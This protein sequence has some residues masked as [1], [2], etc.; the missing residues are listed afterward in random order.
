[1]SCLC[2]H[3]VERSDAKVQCVGC[4]ELF[5]LNCANLLQRDWDYMKKYNIPHHCVSCKRNRRNSLR[6]PPHNQQVH[7]VDDP[8]VSTIQPQP[9][10]PAVVESAIPSP[11]NNAPKSSPTIAAAGEENS[12]PPSVITLD[13]LYSEI[14]SLKQMN[15]NALLLITT[16][17]ADKK[18]LEVKVNKLQN[19]VNALQQKPL[20]KCIDIVGIPNVDNDNAMSSAVKLLAEGLGEKVTEDD[21]KSC[22]VKTI[23]KKLPETK[24]NTQSCTS[25]KLG[26]SINIVRIKFKSMEC[27]ERIITSKRSKKLTSGIFGKKFGN[28]PIFINESLSN[29]NR[30]LFYKAQKVK[31]EKDFSFVWVNNGVILLRKK[32]GDKVIRIC[33]FED[34]D[35]LS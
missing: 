33:S 30:S 25:A 11:L 21:V 19:M 27:K 8:C 34:L 13:V 2:G 15:S 29:F 18:S 14:I 10:S 1:M 4:H 28:K 3:K 24:N 12:T 17:Q 20:R 6:S 32:E 23:A 22:Y 7:D 31:T 9:T 5:H 26:E 35:K 16:L